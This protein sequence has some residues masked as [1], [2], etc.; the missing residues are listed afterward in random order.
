MLSLCAERESHLDLKPYGLLRSYWLC[1]FPQ[2]HTYLLRSPVICRRCLSPILKAVIFP[3]FPLR[4]SVCLLLS[5]SVMSFAS[6]GWGLFTCLLIFLNDVYD[7]VGFPLWK[8]PKLGETKTS[9]LHQSFGE[10]P[11]SFLSFFLSF[12]FLFLTGV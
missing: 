9:A 10:C 2:L 6:G 11:K 12:F 5:P 7:S 3:D 4:F 8:S 1:F